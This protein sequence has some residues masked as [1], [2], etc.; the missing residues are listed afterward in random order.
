M[1]D[2]W[3]NT[4]TWVIGVYVGVNMVYLGTYLMF[5]ALAARGIDDATQ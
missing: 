5:T 3:P 1:W 2:G 4:A